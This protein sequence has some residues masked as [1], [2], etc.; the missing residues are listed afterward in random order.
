MRPVR[1]VVQRVAIAFST[2]LLLVFCAVWFRMLG[3]EVLATTWQP[4]DATIVSLSLGEVIPGSGPSIPTDVVSLKII[5]FLG[6]LRTEKVHDYFLAP[7]QLGGFSAIR[8]LPSFSQRPAQ[9]YRD[10]YISVPCWLLAGALSVVPITAFFRGPLRRWRRVRR[11][12][13]IGC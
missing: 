1:Q 11:G 10:T 8:T 3:P 6:E 12:E 13:C 5:S 7:L 9:S 4:S 2:L